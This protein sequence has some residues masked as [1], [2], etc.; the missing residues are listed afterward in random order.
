[1]NENMKLC[2]FLAYFTRQKHFFRR[3]KAA[4]QTLFFLTKSQNHS[5][6]FWTFSTSVINFQEMT[7]W[8][9]EHM[10]E[11]EDRIED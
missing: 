3:S 11:V 1:M 6:Q 7:I 4:L 5:V 9:R 2:S 8:R 10:I